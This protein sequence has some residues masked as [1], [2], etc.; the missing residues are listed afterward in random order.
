[1]TSRFFS[2]T[3]AVGTLLVVFFVHPFAYV[4][5]KTANFSHFGSNDVQYDDSNASS[6]RGVESDSAIDANTAN[7][8]GSND[9]DAR[10]GSNG[11]ASPWLKLERD[12]RGVPLRLAT[13][14][15]RFEGEF[16][17]ADGETRPVSIDLIGAIHLGE[18]SYYERLNAEFKE[19]ETVVFELVA[20]EGFDVKDLAAA[21]E[22]KNKRGAS[23]LDAVSFLQ[24]SLSDALGL[25][26]QTDGV[27]YSAPNLKR[28]DADADDFLVRLT[29]GGDI[30]L[31]FANSSLESLFASE[32]G[33]FEGWALA[34]FLAKDKRLTLRRLFADELA[35]T[36]LAG[37]PDARETALIHFR[38]EIATDVVKKELEAGKTKIA[39]FYGAAHLDDLAR[40]IEKTLTNS[41]RLEP[42]WITA[43]SMEPTAK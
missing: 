27:D 8:S 11:D 40:R 26:Y 12:E 2:S 33:R 42:R 34:Y 18:A 21:K 9:S 10:A 38:N 7:A 32:N 15:V 16:R 25:V 36:E 17:A 30:P 1:M 22:S 41:R 3:L 4:G 13:S 23:P 5:A 28:G 35:R 31:F 37:D 39:V 19:Y 24:Q 14:I 20:E 29:T 6:D 43:W